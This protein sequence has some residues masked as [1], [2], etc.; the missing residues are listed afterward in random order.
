MAVYLFTYHAYLSWLPDR[1]QGYVDKGQGIQ[2][3]DP[4]KADQYRRNAKESGVLFDQ[5]VQRAMIE[6][7][8]AAAKHQRFT[9][10]MLASDATHFHALI[11][12]RDDRPFEKLRASLRESLTRRL[13]QSFHRRTWLAEKQSRKRVKDRAHLEYLCVEYLPRHDGLK[14][15]PGR[16]VFG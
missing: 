6:E 16:G 1:P 11:S 13:N 12:W 14:Y 3:C 5:A 8:Q 15:A 7:T 10:H 2:P 9:V 4:D